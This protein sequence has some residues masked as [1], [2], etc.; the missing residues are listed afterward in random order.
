MVRG[1][2]LLSTLSLAILW[3]WRTPN[4]IQ[5][6]LRKNLRQ[7][8]LVKNGDIWRILLS[9]GGIGHLGFLVTRTVRLPHGIATPMQLQDLLKYRSSLQFLEYLVSPIK[10][11]VHAPF[12]L[13]YF[14]KYSLLAFGLSGSTWR[15]TPN[16]GR[17]HL[18][19][20]RYTPQKWL[21]GRSCYVASRRWSQGTD[22]QGKRCAWGARVVDGMNCLLSTLAILGKRTVEPAMGATDN[23]ERLTYHMIV[24]GKR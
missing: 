17:I 9:R 12:L 10:P 15:A 5:T 14:F 18:G 16:W 22:I 13:F 11:Q 8:I 1:G 6:R 23:L 21:S 19:T 20:W 3:E 24:W 4:V 7:P 2:M